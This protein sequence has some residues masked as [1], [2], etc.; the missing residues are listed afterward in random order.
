[1][2][3]RSL[4]APRPVVPADVTWTHAIYAL[5]AIGV[6]LGILTSAYVVTAFLFGVPS[7]VAVILNY[8]KR[9]DVRGTYL[10]SHFQWQLR[11]FWFALLW[12]VV[13][14]LISLPFMLVLIGFGTLWAA[15]VAIGLWVIYRVI[16]GWVRLSAGQPMYA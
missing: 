10:E 4:V 13:A 8:V 14:F 12:I 7:I 11:T 5:H 9:N 3:D 2:T 6:S 1:M 16:R 15:A